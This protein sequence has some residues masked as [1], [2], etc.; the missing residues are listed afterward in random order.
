VGKAIGM[1]YVPTELSAPGSTIYVE[2]RGKLL[3]AEVVSL[4]FW[5]AN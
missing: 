1:G 3:K 4:P 5:K 2:I